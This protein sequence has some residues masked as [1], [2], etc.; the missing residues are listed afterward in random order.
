MR[1]G[2][3]I[4]LLIIAACGLAPIS[5]A[6]AQDDAVEAAYVTRGHQTE[7]LQRVYHERIERLHGAL[8]S[9]LRV[10]AP[11]QVD[12]L[13]P[14]PPPDVFGYQLIPSLDLDGPP[15]PP[16]T[17]SQVASYSWKWSDTLIKRELQAI[18]RLEAELAQVPRSADARAAVEKVA[19]GYRQAVANRKAVD[20]DMAYNWTWQTQIAGNRPLFDRLEKTQQMVLKRE[21]IEEALASGDE[22]RWRAA[23]GRAGVDVPGDA[24]RLRAA[25][26]ERAQSL[27]KDISAATNWTSSRSFLRIERPQPNHWLVTVPLYTDI[28][29]VSFVEGFVHAVETLW[30]VS[31]SQ[32][33]GTEEF[34]VHVDLQRISPERLYCRHDSVS[35]GSVDAC[36]PPARGVHIDVDAHVGRFPA[37]GAILTTGASLLR[38]VGEHAI[39]LGPQA[40]SPHVLAH[41][42]GHLVGFPDAYFRGYRNAGPDGFVVTELAD[43]ADI[44]GAPGAG[45][46]LPRHFE[47]LIANQAKALLNESMTLYDQRRYAEALDAA[48]GAVSL[49]PTFAEGYNN[50]AV[51]FAGLAMWDEAIAA[52]EEAVRLKS[53]FQ[54]ARNNLAWVRQERAKAGASTSAK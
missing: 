3:T 26:T 24:E 52:A 45:P 50:M 5:T 9:V 6:V 39:A 30:H 10:V 42:F 44:M 11:E 34:R 47:T 14:P 54:L 19:S 43:L 46:V 17:K 16:G 22:F 32:A 38:F 21:A 25:L 51:G 2:R 29:D 8:T 15:P 18:E 31:R 37:G 28:T 1:P 23:A 4:G 33:E 27:S 20:S 53:D 36:T 35:A 41:E 48:R 13:A 40:V 7:A 12:T 49:D